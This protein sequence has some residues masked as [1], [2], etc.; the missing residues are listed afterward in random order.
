[1]LAEPQ[2]GPASRPVRRR[3]VG[4]ALLL[5]AL[6]AGPASAQAVAPGAGAEPPARASGV[7]RP[8]AQ[9]DQ[10]MVRPTPNLPAQS[11]PVIHPRRLRRKGHGTVQV[12]PK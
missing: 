1:M 2:P 3:P 12:V 10:G 4:L 9:V 11:T 8:P 5:A 6:S 7:V